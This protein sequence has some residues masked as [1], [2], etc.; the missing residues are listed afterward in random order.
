MVFP[1]FF[2]HPHGVTSAKLFTTFVQNACA[3]VRIDQGG[4]SSFFIEKESIPQENKKRNFLQTS[5]TQTR[6]HVAIRWR[7][8]VHDP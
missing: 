4:A 7:A 8:P 6:E 3:A 2:S 1:H 5:S